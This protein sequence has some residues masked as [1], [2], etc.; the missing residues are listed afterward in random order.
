MSDDGENNA[1]RKALPLPVSVVLIA[2]CRRVWK[3]RAV[4]LAATDDRRIAVGLLAAAVNWTSAL[5]DCRPSRCRCSGCRPGSVGSR[6]C[7]GAC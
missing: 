6:G 4:V 2:A 3:S 7:A 1:V 5:I